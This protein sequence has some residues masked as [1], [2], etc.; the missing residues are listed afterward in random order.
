[1]KKFL[2][3]AVASLLVA[4]VVYAQRRAIK[5]LL[6]GPYTAVPL[7]QGDPSGFGD[8]DGGFSLEADTLSAAHPGYSV[9]KAWCELKSNSTITGGSLKWWKGTALSDGTIDWGRVSGADETVPNIGKARWVSAPVTVAGVNGRI[10]CQPSAVTESG[11][12]G[13]LSLT[14]GFR[15]ESY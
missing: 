14:Y 8:F 9:T 13:G 4:G 12:D 15:L 10:Y 2:F 6:K 11:A 1:M 5:V 7:S 3:A